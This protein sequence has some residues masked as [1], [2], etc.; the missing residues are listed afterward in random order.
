MSGQAHGGDIYRNK[1]ALD[2]SVNVNP[3]GAPES[4]IKAVRDAAADIGCYPDIQCESLVRAISRFERVPKEDVI[5]GNGAAELFFAAV[6]AVKPKRALLLTP[7]FA[8]Y[9]R[10]LGA[11]N[12]QITYYQTLSEKMFEP[13]ESLLERITPETDMIFLCNPNNPTGRLFPKELLE[14]LLNRCRRYQVFLILDEC[15]IDFLKEP[16]KIEMTHKRDSYKNLLIIKAFTKLFAMPGLRLGYGISGNRELLRKMQD[17]LQPWN[18]SLP[19]QA[20]GVAAL[21][22]CGEY[23]VKD[24]LRETR[25]Y[26]SEEREYLTA[27]LSDMGFYVYPSKVNYIF[28]SGKSGLYYEA[29]KDGFLIR[30]CSGYRGLSP[31]YYRIAVRTNKE[32]ERLAAWMKRKTRG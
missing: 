30:D 19:A 29:L 15:F 7:S 31:G 21:T 23:C 1:V 26:V 8:E 9:E 17:V 32:N 18:V 14:R 2:F 27:V 10:A 20:A 11:V 25:K 24:Y 16:E 22:D 12:A 6:Q 13:E 5:C 28:F 4:V 3:L